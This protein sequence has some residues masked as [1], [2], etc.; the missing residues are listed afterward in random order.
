MRQLRMPEILNGE[1]FFSIRVDNRYFQPYVTR[2]GD[3]DIA[4]QE[5]DPQKLVIIPC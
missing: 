1:M 2:L 4:R 5:S 3:V